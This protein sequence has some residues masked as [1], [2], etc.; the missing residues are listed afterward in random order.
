VSIEEAQAD[1][2]ALDQEIKH[3]IDITAV[4]GWDQETYLPEGAVENRGEQLALLEGYTH[5]LVTSDKMAKALEILEQNP[6]P[7]PLTQ[8]L[9]QHLGRCT[10]GAAS[11]LKTWLSGKLPW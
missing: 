4:L 3:L 2:H 7:S 11:F 5:R 6:S 10:T 9:V 8:D 1:L